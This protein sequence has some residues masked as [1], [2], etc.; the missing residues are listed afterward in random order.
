MISV[1]DVDIVTTLRVNVMQHMTDTVINCQE[2]N[3]LDV[4]YATNY[5]TLYTVQKEKNL[6]NLSVSMHLTV[7]VM[8]NNMYVYNMKYIKLLFI[9]IVIFLII[10][11]FGKTIEPAPLGGLIQLTAKGPQDTYLTRDAWKYIPPWYWQFGSQ[12]RWGTWPP[13]GPW[14]PW[15]NPTY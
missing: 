14:G 8:K 3:D 7:I 6:K 13:W 12:D 9:I 11:I 15:N 5:T 4:K 2:I 1:L 10:F